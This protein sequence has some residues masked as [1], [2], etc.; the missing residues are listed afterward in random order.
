M[1]P[2]RQLTL[3]GW[4]KL[5]AGLRPTT[6]TRLRYMVAMLREQVVE[7][8]LGQ[9]LVDSDRMSSSRM[10]DDLSLIM[11]KANM[12]VGLPIK[13]VSNC[14]TEALGSEFHYS[15]HC[16]TSLSPYHT[17]ICLVIHLE[18]STLC[19]RLSAS[20]AMTCPTP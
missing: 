11:V 17:V 1:S 18:H 5:N 12:L 15:K 10:I 20:V 13:S 8:S 3:D 19:V 9:G 2:I 4:G 6:V 16:W 14:G 7:L